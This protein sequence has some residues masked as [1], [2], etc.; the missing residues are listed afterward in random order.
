[1]IRQKIKGTKVRRQQDPEEEPDFYSAK[2]YLPLTSPVPPPPSP[3]TKS[4]EKFGG[5]R[6]VSAKSKAS[7]ARGK[8]KRKSPKSSP[9]KARKNQTA[10]AAAPSLVSVFHEAASAPFGLAGDEAPSSNVSTS[11]S[12]LLSRPVGVPLLIPRTVSPHQNH[13]HGSLLHVKTQDPADIRGGDLLFFEGQPFRYLEHLD[14]TSSMDTRPSL[15]AP[16]AHRPFAGAAV[17][18]DTHKD[19]IGAT[20]MTAAPAVPLKGMMD[21]GFNLNS[22]ANYQYEAP[23]NTFAV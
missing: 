10:A 5:R 4:K 17:T 3:T 11:S 8:S 7:P 12:E 1:M 9:K 6:K 14:L 2:G 19:T 15:L 18:P 21:A 22:P 16:T 23:R 13:Q 20:I